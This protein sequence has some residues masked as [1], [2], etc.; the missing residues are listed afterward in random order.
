MALFKR[1]RDEV[2]LVELAGARVIQTHPLPARR[3]VLGSAPSCDIVLD[4][5][6]VAPEH[7]HLEAQGAGRWL[8]TNRAVNG[9]YVNG[10]TVTTGVVKLGDRIEFGG[11]SVCEI[12]AATAASR[13]PRAAREAPEALSAAGSATSIGARLAQVFRSPF[14]IAI[15][16][17]WGLFFSWLGL[18]TT[19]SPG[20]ATLPKDVTAALAATATYLRS[21]AAL[22]AHAQLRVEP[23]ALAP[24]RND[25]GAL[26]FALNGARLAEGTLDEALLGRLLERLEDTL[27]TAWAVESQ[28]RSGD[29]RALYAKVLEIVPDPKVPA[30]RYAATKLTTLKP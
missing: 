14:A 5:T 11:N 4:D 7:A 26:Y 6:F 17:L 28:G 23:A 10:V 16:V 8:L 27:L 21:D 2:V 20:D 18:K 3:L 12:R 30:A 19:S 29:A 15:I 9:T 25:P 1:D 22:R 24:P 13:G